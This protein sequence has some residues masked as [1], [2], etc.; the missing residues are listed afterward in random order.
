MKSFTG[1]TLEN[2]SPSWLSSIDNVESKSLEYLA[3]QVYQ[4]GYINQDIQKC[5]RKNGKLSKNSKEY[6][7]YI[8][9][10]IN[11]IDQA[12]KNSIILKPGTVLWRGTYN[13]DT[14]YYT[15]KFTDLG[16]VSTAKELNYTVKLWSANGGKILKL[17]ITDEISGI[18]MN[19]YLDNVDIDGESQQEIL[20]PRGL[21][22]TKIEE[23][24]EYVVYNVSK[25]KIT[26]K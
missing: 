24:N 19:T 10:Q 9:Q 6:K 13:T 23:N 1:F 14:E 20:L 18:D 25:T 15:D 16:Y 17:I 11:N 5:L 8:I 21:T 12:F 22:F 7:E 3:V 2:Y 26:A 4:N